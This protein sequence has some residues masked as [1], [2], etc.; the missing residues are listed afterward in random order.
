M[1]MIAKEK[2][3][4]YFIYELMYIPVET[5]MCDFCLKLENNAMLFNLNFI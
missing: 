5:I 3:Q 1:K 2:L 4:K